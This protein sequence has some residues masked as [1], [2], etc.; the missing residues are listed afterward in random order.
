MIYFLLH[1]ALKY[2]SM[3]QKNMIKILKNLKLKVRI[4]IEYNYALSSL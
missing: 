3:I 4:V 2:S 1:L